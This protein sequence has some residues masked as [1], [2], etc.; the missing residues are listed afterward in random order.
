MKYIKIKQNQ[1]PETVN[2]KIIHALYEHACADLNNVTSELEGYITSVHA[3]ETDVT[4]LTAKFPNLNINITGDFYVPF[5]DKTAQQ[6]IADAFGDGVGI[7]GSNIKRVYYNGS[8]NDSN[9]YN[10]RIGVHNLF[11][12]SSGTV[13]NTITSFEEFELFTGLEGNLGQYC[14]FKFYNQ[15][16]LRGH[17]TIPP[18]VTKISSFD[19]FR[20]SGIDSIY[21]NNVTE[22]SVD[23]MVKDAPNLKAVFFGENT[24]TFSRS[25]RMGLPTANS[26]CVA[27]FMNKD[28]DSGEYTVVDIAS[29]GG[30][31]LSWGGGNWTFYV[32]GALVQDWQ[33]TNSFLNGHV[34]SIDDIPEQYKAQVTEYYGYEFTT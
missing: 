24:N 25:G 12:D 19:M 27:V 32:P 17:I 18:G 14:A 6:V 2:A 9:K 33:T 29:Q 21:L 10:A 13:Y 1:V 28:V 23:T 8:A 30:A 31:L 15:T 34:Q 20:N 11:S 4:E 3:Y 26:G 22:I 16:T 5:K 7:I